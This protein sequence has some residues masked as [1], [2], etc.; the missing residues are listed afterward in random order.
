MEIKLVKE[1]LEEYLSI[2]QN[3][4]RVFDHIFPKT[5]QVRNDPWD[6]TPAGKVFWQDYDEAEKVSRQ[7]LDIFDYVDKIFAEKY[8]GETWD[9]F[10][11]HNVMGDT[12]EELSSRDKIKEWA[13]AM[14]DTISESLDFDEE[15]DTAPYYR[16]I[17]SL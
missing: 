6:I 3:N 2:G 11:S 14:I 5:S 13:K 4:P 7:N 8:P 10:D 9:N 12:A 17:D 15:F 16:E 1:S